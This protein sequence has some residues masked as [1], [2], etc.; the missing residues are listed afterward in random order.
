MS[1]IIQLNLYVLPECTNI[2]LGYRNDGKHQ[3]SLVLKHLKSIIQPD[4]YDERCL[5]VTHTHG[6]WIQWMNYRRMDRRVLYEDIIH[7]DINFK[8]SIVCAKVPRSYY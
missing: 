6:Q 1:L 4:T 7:H 8:K 2:I 5:I 3:Y